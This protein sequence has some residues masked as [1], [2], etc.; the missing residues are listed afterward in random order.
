MEPRKSRARKSG[1]EPHRLNQR[2]L[3][4]RSTLVLDLATRFAL[5]DA[6]LM[7]AAHQP[8]PLIVISAGAAFAASF[9]FLDDQIELVILDVLCGCGSLYS[10]SRS[11]S[12]ASTAASGADPAEPLACWPAAR[13]RLCFVAH[14]SPT[15]TF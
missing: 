9:K 7:Y 6:A 13:S 8:G 14:T 15:C 3:S 1:R 4:I 2:K 5:A 10:C 12:C 11:R